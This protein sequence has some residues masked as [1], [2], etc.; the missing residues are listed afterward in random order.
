MVLKA[1]A[2]APED[3]FGGC[4]EMAEAL[5]GVGKRR[6]VALESA[7][8]PAARKEEVKTPPSPPSP[9]KPG[10]R[11]GVTSVVAPHLK[12]IAC[13]V[14][15]LLGIYPYRPN[16]VVGCTVLYLVSLSI[17]LLFEY[18]SITVCEKTDECGLG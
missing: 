12:T 6:G 5:K 11:F 1:M 10:S 3:R 8:V 7:G 14:I 2:K 15:V 18:V 13:M 4:G 16:S 9:A 17:V